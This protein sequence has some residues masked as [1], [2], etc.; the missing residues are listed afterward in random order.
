MAGKKGRSGRRPGSFSWSRSPTAFAG[1][2]LNV[3]IEL[4]LGGVPIPT[5]PG[6]WLPQPTERRYTVPPRIKR[7]LALMAIEHAM[8][9]YPHLGRPEVA[10]VLAWARRRAPSI[11][12]RRPARAKPDAR[13]RAYRAVGRRLANAW[14]KK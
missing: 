8:G 2:H 1:H 9:L 12:L 3:L 14:K 10:A 7:V 5:R 13:E 4:W 6:R 11:T